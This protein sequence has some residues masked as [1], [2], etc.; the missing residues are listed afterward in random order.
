MKNKTSIL[1][2]RTF[3]FKREWP[4]KVNKKVMDKWIRFGDIIE[5]TT[6][7]YDEESYLEIFFV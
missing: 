5:N 4:R 1:F 6:L 7:N 3:S 2:A